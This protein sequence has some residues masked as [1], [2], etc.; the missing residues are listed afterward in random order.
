MDTDRYD[1]SSL[2]V[3]ASRKHKINLSLLVAETALWANPEVHK[4]LL[5]ENKSG[6]FYPNVRRARKG[7]EKRG[8][9]VGGVKLDDNTYANY[10]IRQAIG[11]PPKNNKLIGFATCHIWPLT[12]YD[13]KYHTAIPNLVLLPASLA[14]LTDHNPIQAVLQYRSFELYKWVP[15]GEQRPRKPRDYPDCWKRP[16]GFTAKI[17]KA[18]KNRRQ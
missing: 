8:D 14:S 7:R 11:I 13:E 4:R 15:D 2:L 6:A 10:A 3:E 18:I 5:E 12:C 17:E 16:F 1:G 9:V